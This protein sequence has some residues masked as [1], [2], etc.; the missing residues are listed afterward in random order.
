MQYVLGKIM[1]DKYWKQLF[2]GTPYINK[3][4]PSQFYIKS[5]NVNRTIESVES[6]LLGLLE[7]LPP[8]TLPVDQLGNSLPPFVHASE[9]QPK[10]KNQTSF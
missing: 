4:H 9:Y 7:N 8:S 5:T 2:E 1:Y 10:K 3:Y 6:Q